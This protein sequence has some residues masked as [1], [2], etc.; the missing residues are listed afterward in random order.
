MRIRFVILL[1][2]FFSS[3]SIQAQELRCDIQVNAQK[4]SGLDQRVFQRMQQSINDFMNNRAWTQDPFTAN[5]KI[6]C[7]LLILLESNPAQ[8]VFEGSITV[9][10]TRPVF[11][12]TYNSPMV[13]F[14]DLDFKFTYTENTPIDFNA[15]QYISNLSSVLSY[16][17]YLFIALDYESM[18]KGGGAKYFTIMES[19]LNQIPANGPESKGWNA[20]DRNPVSGNRNRF[21]LIT[22][23]Q[24][25]RF[26]VFKDALTDYHLKGLDIMYEKPKEG[27]I[28]ILGALENLLKVF[29]DNPNNPLITIFMQ[30]KSEELINVFS[31]SEQAEKVK[32]VT[33]CKR[34]DPTNAMKYDRIIKGN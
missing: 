26:S 11:N 24:N 6:E 10:S 2:S 19:I 13:N 17:A 7:S 34:L 8:D 29:A 12:S 27:R 16:Y 5:E 21:N 14:R 18:G 32:A 30:T 22:D 33:V 28:A 25:P 1:F 3:L 31:Q 4:I 15:F 20:F 9:Q 23:L